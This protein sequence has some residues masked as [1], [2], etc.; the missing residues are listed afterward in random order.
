MPR[1]DE[2][3]RWIC[4]TSIQ[5]NKLALSYRCASKL[6]NVLYVWDKYWRYTVVDEIDLLAQAVDAHCRT[7]ILF[8]WRFFD[9]PIDHCELV[10]EGIPFS[11]KFQT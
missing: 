9:N 8:F 2:S 11:C 7:L 5:H 10:S 6:A 3:I 4:A 1:V